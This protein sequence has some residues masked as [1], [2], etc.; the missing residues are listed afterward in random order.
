MGISSVLRHV[1][2]HR[3]E[4]EQVFHLVTSDLCVCDLLGLEKQPMLVSHI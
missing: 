1:T 2:F 3:L 4:A